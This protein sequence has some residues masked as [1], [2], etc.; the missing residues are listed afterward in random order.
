ML[1]HPLRDPLENYDKIEK[2]RMDFTYN[3]N[4]DSAFEDVISDTN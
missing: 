2:L 3:I 1:F 4:Q